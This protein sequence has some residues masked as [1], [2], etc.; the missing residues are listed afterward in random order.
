MRAAYAINMLPSCESLELTQPDF[1]S[2]IASV[3]NSYCSVQTRSS[4]PSLQLSQ[5][6]SSVVAKAG[7]C[8]RCAWQTFLA[9]IFSFT[10]GLKYQ[11]MKF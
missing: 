11:L 4:D 1:A 7:D 6:R 3:T 5:A 9:T 2:T 8:D 10:P